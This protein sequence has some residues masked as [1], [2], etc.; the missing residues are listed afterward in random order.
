MRV[1][2]VSG[3]ASV[4]KSETAKNF[5]IV[6]NGSSN[7]NR[8]AD[9]KVIDFDSAVWKKQFPHRIDSDWYIHYINDIQ[10]TIQLYGDSGNIND[11]V[12]LISSHLDVIQYLLKRGYKITIVRPIWNSRHSYL[13]MLWSRVKREGDMH[14]PNYCAAH[15]YAVNFKAYYS[16]VKQLATGPMKNLVKIINVYSAKGYYLG[17]HIWDII[18]DIDHCMNYNDR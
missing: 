11:L 8:R 2:I 18:N 14:D 16:A 3:W 7:N 6:Y 17:D 4:G 10:S 9:V 1:H 12:I 5:D 13:N 15:A